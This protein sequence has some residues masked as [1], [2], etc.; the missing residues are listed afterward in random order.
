MLL[1][2]GAWTKHIAPRRLEERKFFSAVDLD[3]AQRS[4]D[5]SCGVTEHVLQRVGTR[6]GCATPGQRRRADG[7]G[8]SGRVA[9]GDLSS[10][11]LFMPFGLLVAWCSH[12]ARLD[13]GL[14]ILYFIPAAIV[15]SQWSARQ[16]RPR[17]Y[18]QSQVGLM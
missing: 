6:N 14:G 17:R 1:K 15:C 12:A 13:P 16:V 3:G 10:L 2:N 5:R 11:I 7:S 4:G 9:L 18:G 8:L